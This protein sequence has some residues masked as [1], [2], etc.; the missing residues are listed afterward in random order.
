MKTKASRRGFTLIELL[1]VVSIIAMMAGGAYLGYSAQIPGF[2]ARQAATQSRVIH[3]WLIGYANEHG[4]NFPEGETAN[5]AYRELFKSN[6]GADERQFAITGDAWHKAAP[7]GEPDGDAGAGPEFLQALEAGECAFAYVNGLSS[8][9]TARLPLVANAFSAETGVW[10]KRKNEIG[11]V[12]QGRFG[13]ICR[14]GGSAVAH[15]ISGTELAVKEKYNGQLM[16]VFTP[17]FEDMSFT[18]V[19]PQR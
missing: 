5:A 18:V 13:V 7:R 3:G 12:F 4:G 1:V 17:G 15:D 9:D 14:V 11:G 8:S 19:N 6:L 2:R 16:N 10:S